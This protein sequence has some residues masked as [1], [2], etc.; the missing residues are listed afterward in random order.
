M[1]ALIRK[2][3]EFT[4]LLESQLSRV[5]ELEQFAEEVQARGHY[6]SQY[7][8]QRMQAILARRDRLQVRI[9]LCLVLV[10]VPED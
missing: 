7:I 6:H 10:D 2:H 3:G 4:K 9:R 8:Q 1:E 5:Q